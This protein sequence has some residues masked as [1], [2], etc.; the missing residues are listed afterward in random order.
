MKPR[1]PGYNGTVSEDP[2][3]AQHEFGIEIVREGEKTTVS[4]PL[5]L[6]AERCYELFCDVDTIPKWLSVVRSTAVRKRDKQGRALDVAFLGSLQRASVGY[7]LR[8]SYDDEAREVRWHHGGGGVEQ[9]A[10]S[11]CFEPRADGGCILHYALLTELPD[12]LPPWADELY[13]KD[14]AETVV[15]DFCEWV[16]SHDQER[17]DDA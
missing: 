9:L 1:A 6:D 8:Y 3:S 11:A 15:I 4:A 5:R 14:P 12:R 16:D 13:Q 2:Q 7:S 10:G 17:D